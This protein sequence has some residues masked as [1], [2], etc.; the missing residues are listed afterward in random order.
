MDTNKYAKIREI[1][2]NTNILSFSIVDS[3]DIDNFLSRINVF[4][5]VAETLIKPPK[6]D[7]N[8]E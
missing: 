6:C 4:M 1:I 8:V 5:R 7:R 3:K 2:S